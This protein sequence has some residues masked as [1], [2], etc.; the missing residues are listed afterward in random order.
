MRFRTMVFGCGKASPLEAR[1]ATYE[2]KGKCPEYSTTQWNEPEPIRPSDPRATF[3]KL[4]RINELLSRKSTK[5]FREGSPQHEWSSQLMH[6]KR[7]FRSIT[8]FWQQSQPGTKMIKMTICTWFSWWPQGCENRPQ[9]HGC[10]Q[11]C[12]NRPQDHGC[13]Q[14]WPSWAE[15]PI[16]PRNTSWN[17]PW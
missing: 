6:F 1:A 2:A 10:V 4:P 12:E 14:G 11:G 9:D 17:L 8:S 3:G 5:I 16:C 7:T 13:V 15:S